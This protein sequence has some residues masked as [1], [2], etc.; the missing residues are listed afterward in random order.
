MFIKYLSDNHSKLDKDS[1]AK[2]INKM[3]SK[4]YPLNSVK[5]NLIIEEMMYHYESG[6]DTRASLDD[7]FESVINKIVYF[8]GRK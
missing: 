4:R 6:C 1:A 8:G 5:A 3:V 2:Y 7:V